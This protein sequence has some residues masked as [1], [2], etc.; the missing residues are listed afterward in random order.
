MKIGARVGIIS[1]GEAGNLGDDL[2]LIAVVDAIHRAIPDVEVTFLSHG[3]KLDLGSIATRLG[4]PAQPS[5][6]QARA[7]VPLTWDNR[8]SFDRCD[9]VIFGGGGLLQTSHSPDRPYAWLSYLPD[10]SARPS[11]LAVGLGLG[12][13]DAIWTQRLR[14]IGSPFDELWVRDEGSEDLATRELDWS[15]QR[16]HDFIDREF[17]R[18]LKL[19]DTRPRST[20]LLGV[21]LRAWPGLATA[22]VAAKVRTIA[23]EHE[24]DQVRYFVLET[25]DGEGIDVTFTR[26]IAEEAGVA[27]ETRVYRGS[28]ALDF[29]TEMA[30]VDVALSMKL[31]SSAIWAS[32][33]IPMYPIYYAPKIAAFFG[34]EWRGLDISKGVHPPAPVIGATPRAAAVVRDR[35]P[36]LLNHP[37]PP[38][39]GR[40]SD[41]ARLAF[42]VR[43][44]GRAACTRLL[45]RVAFGGKNS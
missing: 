27:S 22:D 26:R 39:V 6:V 7:E 35:L 2:I 1:L 3:E 23:R 9:A 18:A 43:R 34:V 25:T 15:A 13:L 4:W 41:T 45:R 16:C 14:R 42:M 28:E 21:A 11:V 36:A 8:R 33:D 24:C 17:L 37:S 10:S 31:H 5:R 19:G 12:P 29:V 30:D 40:F 32:R 44:L 20:K 38:Q